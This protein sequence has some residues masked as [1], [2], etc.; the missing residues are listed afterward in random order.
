MAHVNTAMGQR[1]AVKKPACCANCLDMGTGHG[2]HIRRFMFEEVWR[3]YMVV[4]GGFWMEEWLCCV[5]LDRVRSRRYLL[6]SGWM[7]SKAMAVASSF[8]L[9]G[10][11][12]TSAKL[13]CDT[14][15]AQHLTTSYH[16]QS[17]L[18]IHLRTHQ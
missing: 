5:L 7:S 8:V 3:V 18:R 9:H 2:F 10:V 12:G 6:S 13:W 11:V 14:Y 15:S 4:F 16:R 17:M 1:N